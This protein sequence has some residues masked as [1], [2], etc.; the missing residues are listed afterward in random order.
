MKNGLQ[1]HWHHWE[2]KTQDEHKKTQ[3]KQITKMKSNTTEPI[4]TQG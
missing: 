3:H 1:R 4:N 2:H